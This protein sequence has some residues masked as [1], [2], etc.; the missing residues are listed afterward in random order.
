MAIIKLKDLII[1]DCWRYISGTDRRPGITTD[2]D[3]PSPT[4]LPEGWDDYGLD[5][6][7]E[8]FQNNANRKVELL[9]HYRDSPSPRPLELKRRD[10]RPGD[11]FQY[12]DDDEIIPGVA[13]IS[14][15]HIVDGRNVSY[16]HKPS[17]WLVSTDGSARQRMDSPVRRIPK[18][19]QPFVANPGPVI[20]PCIDPFKH[21][22]DAIFVLEKKHVDG[23]NGKECLWRYE[24]GQRNE[25]IAHNGVGL[26]CTHGDY[27]LNTAQIEHAQALWSAKLKLKTAEKAAE[28]AE[29]ER[30]RVVC[31]DVDEMPNMAFVDARIDQ[32]H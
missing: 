13:S 27:A 9:E 5:P 4:D 7:C 20:L 18:W 17:D 31:D 19:D 3:A 22:H 1:G 29:R 26:V 12:L 23:L 8:Y 30:M 25:S 32:S 21:L 11:C 24:N 10:L 28:D 14:C 2:S 15:P 6:E 16:L